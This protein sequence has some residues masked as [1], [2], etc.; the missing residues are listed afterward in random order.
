MTAFQEREF[1]AREPGAADALDELVDL[2]AHPRPPKAASRHRDRIGDGL[3]RR[4]LAR[5]PLS[6]AV[7]DANGTLP[8]WNE[9][10][11]FLFGVPPLMAVER[12][13]LAG[14]L[15]RIGN[16]T[17]PQRDRIVAFANAHIAAGDRTEPDG[18]LRLSLG[19]ASR[20]AIQIHGL[21][22]GRWMLVFDDGKV[23]AA[24]NPA[25]P[26]SGDAWLDFLT[27]LSNRR[28]FNEM[29][30]DALVHA[31]AETPHAVLL[32]DLDRFASVNETAGHS[33]GDALLCLAAQRLRRE[34]RDNDLLARLGGDEFALMIPNG[35]GAEALA[36]RALDMLAQPFLIEG[37]SVTISASIGMVRFPDHGTSTDDLM[38]LA[39]LALYQAKSAGGRTWRLFDAAMASEAQA[40][41]TDLRKALTLGE[42]SLVYQPCGDMSSHALTGFEARPRWDH[43]VR[44]IVPDSVFMKLAEGNGL[45]VALDEWALKTACAESTGWPASQGQMHQ[46]QMH[47]GPMPL[48]V[49]VRVSSRQ[50]KEANR[51]IGAVKQALEASGLAP[52]RL[53]LKI[54]E[55]SLQGSEVEVLSILHRLRE[56]GVHIALAD[57][58]IGP[59]LLAHLRAFPF[60]A[61]AFPAESL[62]DVTTDA[63]QTSVLCALSAAGFD[64]I[65]CYLGSSL[66]P[67]SGIASVSQLHA[68]SSNHVLV[69]E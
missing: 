26:G 50:F 41:R 22:A 38:H 32:I 63:D 65:S 45:I 61:I 43:P 6:V 48:T 42:F 57:C 62:S 40:R 33:V 44:G 15:E 9:Q 3:A 64:H 60:H 31:T 54:S 10:A 67:T 47:Q 52:G 7:I 68:L 4:V 35:E 58:A 19:R 24:G 66:T 16:L 8:F 1:V 36:A 28:H 18:C 59:S 69:T 25:A 34:T 49:A 51:L 27:G 30:R 13:S 12:P 29:L 5:L 17:Q 53:E 2:G 11:G 14:M 20:I 37:Q 56:L 23:T 39:D 55:T 46:G 21:G